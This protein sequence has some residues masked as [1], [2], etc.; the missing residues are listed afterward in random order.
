MAFSFLLQDPRE[1]R[2]PP[3]GD[4][5]TRSRWAIPATPPAP[6]R[7]RQAGVR[8]CFFHSV[9][10]R[11][12]NFKNETPKNDTRDARIARLSLAQRLR[13]ALTQPKAS[14]S[15]YPAAPVMQGKN[16][17]APVGGTSL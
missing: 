17:P 12:T 2:F 13:P 5:S 10:R 4:R 14:R 6:S 15:L 11:K 1:N 16:L 3:Q 8:R 7:F 9:P